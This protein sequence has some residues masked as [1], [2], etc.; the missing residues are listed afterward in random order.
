MIMRVERGKSVA[1]NHISKIYIILSIFLYNML[2]SASHWLKKT[3]TVMTLALMVV[4]T[5]A[6]AVSAYTVSGGTPPS[7]TVIATT[8]DPSLLAAVYTPSSGVLSGL[9][10]TPSTFK[11]SNG[12]KTTIHFDLIGASQVWLDIMQ[13]GSTVNRLYFNAGYHMTGGGYD[14]QWNGLNGS[15]VLVNDGTYQVFVTAKLDSTG[16]TF[17]AQENVIVVS[18][19]PAQPVVITTGNASPNP[20]NP[21]L[22]QQTFVSY[23]INAQANMNIE[24]VD[25][26]T[27]YQIGGSPL[28]QNAGTYSVS[29]NGKLNGSNAPAKTYYIR[30]TGKNDATPVAYVTNVPVTVDYA[31]VPPVT[32]PKVSYVYAEQASFNP[33]TTTN[34]IHYAVDKSAVAVVKILDASNNT[35]RAFGASSVTNGF[36]YFLNWDGRADSN[37]LVPAGNYTAKV[38]LSLTAG[39]TVVDSKQSTA[40]AVNYG[41]TNTAP[42][43]SSLT[44]NPA[45]INPSNSETTTISYTLDKAANSARVEIVEGTTIRRTIL[46]TGTSSTSTNTVSFNGRDDSNNI[47][48]NGTYT[49]RVLATN[50]YGTG[51][52]T[53]SVTI[54]GNGSTNSAPVVTSVYANPTSFNPTNGET[55]TIFYT[56]DKVANSARV[57]ILEGSTIR[58]TITGT[59]TSSTSTNSVSFNG[60]DDNGNILPVGT[61]TARVS[62]TNT[63][64]T[65]TNSTSVTINNGGNNGNCTSTNGAPNLTNVYASPSTFNP[66]N[67]STSVSFNL[68]RSANITVEILNNNSSLMRTLSDNVC[69]NSGSGSY[70]WDGRDTNGNVVNDGTYTVKVRANNG[71]GSDTE[72]TT[73]TVNRSG[74]GNTSGDLILNLYVQPEIFNPRNG[75]TSTAYYNLNQT[76]TVTTQVLDR[77]GIV[78]RTLVDNIT[79]YSN[80]FAYTTSYGS[81]NYGDQWNGR[82]V[83][84]NIVPDNIYQFRVTANGN[85]QTDTETAWVEV[86]TDGIIIGFPNGSTCGGYIDVSSNSPYCKAILLMKELG[87]FSGYQDG[88][89][90]PYTPINRAETVKVVLLALSIPV[91]ND[92]TT[93]F[94]DT[95]GSAWYAPFLRTAKRLGI[96][97]GYPDGT[98]RPNQTINRVE[99][100][101]VFLESSGVNIPYCNYAPYNDTPLN[102]DTRWYID[103]VC[104]AKSNGLMH[105]DGA[106]RFSPAAA[107][108]RGDVADLFYQFETR[109]LYNQNNN[110]YITG[111]YANCG[112][113]DPNCNYNS[114]Y[115]SSYNYTN[116]NSSSYPMINSINVNPSTFNPYNQSTTISYTLNSG[117]NT[118]TVTITDS[119]SAVR[120]TIS[121][122][123]TSTSNNS[124]SFNG[125]DDSGNVLPRGTYTARVSVTNNFGTTTGTTYLYIQY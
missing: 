17:T 28:T 105:D 80:N 40:F 113:N 7:G 58:R 5:S 47:L 85:G 48:A 115:A 84:G 68:D 112:Y 13:N 18:N 36:D 61:Y 9:K 25:G 108:T 22:G 50:D 70:S 72:Y 24:V 27:T 56:L 124:V 54:T 104:Y 41:T 32:N 64:G 23:T 81:Y 95:D 3:V 103:Y 11:P 63:Y 51:S 26:V 53:A 106:G 6:Q 69:R 97:R 37:A 93:L 14:T 76:A 75:Q 122:A 15:G 78:I 39:G 88:T 38:E 120:R 86:D 82:D 60:R 107:M 117:V 90:R 62:A 20:I 109:G 79:R 42:V 45:S 102:G 66:N 116:Y 29:W 99:L 101:K 87:V 92:S 16:Q 10:V 19:A 77:N 73:V 34:R 1:R 96:I 83:N 89:F 65:G 67:Q 123:G 35:V 98:F 110:P 44:V 118:A 74:G 21:S 55:T 94:R 2:Q 31:T 57:E 100:L 8:V 12:E 43:V 30:F 121:N 52:N 46:N 91:L 59:G 125:R 33:T 111:N 119:N 4:T 71:S 49:V 114:N